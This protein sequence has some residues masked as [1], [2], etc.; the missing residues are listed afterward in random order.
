MATPPRAPKDVIGQRNSRCFNGHFT[1]RPKL[2]KSKFLSIYKSLVTAQSVTLWIHKIL[3][4]RG[5]HCYLSKRWGSEFY[6]LI[7]VV[8]A[9]YCFF[10]GLINFGLMQECP[11]PAIDGAYSRLTP[12]HHA[13]QRSALR[14]QNAKRRKN[15]CCA[16]SRSRH[17]RLAL[18]P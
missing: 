18:A 3:V 2:K 17:A 5:S 14:S 6:G 11:D 1:D 16:A 12:Q 8:L 10:C 9:R 15:R 7:K 4:S 13:T